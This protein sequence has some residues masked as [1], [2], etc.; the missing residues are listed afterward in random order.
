MPGTHAAC[1][2]R[3]VNAN[4]SRGLQQQRIEGSPA[5]EGAMGLGGELAHTHAPPPSEREL[6]RWQ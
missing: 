3:L 4:P 1:H 6:P 5:A 2:S